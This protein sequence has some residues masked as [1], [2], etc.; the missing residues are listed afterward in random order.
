MGPPGDGA[1]A[2]AA[3][4]AAPESAPAAAPA[5]AA[6]AKPPPKAR[7]ALHAASGCGSKPF[8]DPILGQVHH[9][10]YISGDWDVHWG[11]GILTHGQVCRSE[12]KEAQEAPSFDFLGFLWRAKLKVVGQAAPKPSPAAPSQARGILHCVFTNAIGPPCML[13]MSRCLA[14]APASL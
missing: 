7:R 9:P 11:Y 12:E 5:A 6:P 8:W 14:L 1:P 4:A 3:A 13:R 10:F 2:P